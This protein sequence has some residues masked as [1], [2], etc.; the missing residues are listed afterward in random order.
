LFKKHYNST[1]SFFAQA[2]E[3]ACK[4]LGSNAPK[5]DIPAPA[6]TDES[7]TRLGIGE[8]PAPSERVP[9]TRRFSTNDTDFKLPGQSMDRQTLEQTPRHMNNPDAILRIWAYIGRDDPMRGDSRGSTGLAQ[10]VAELL[11]GEMLYVDQAMLDKCFPN[12]REYKEKLRKLIKQKGAPDIVFGTQGYDIRHSSEIRPTMLVS[13]YN[14]DL[15]IGLD[16][17]MNGLVSHDLTPEKLAAAGAEFS[18]RHPEIT[19]DL[20]CIL[21]ADVSAHYVSDTVE[22]L[23]SMCGTLKEPTVY[24]CP[25]RRTYPDEYDSVVKKLKESC[26]T[27]GTEEKIRVITPTISSIRKNYNPYLGL[28]NKA[29]HMVL[30]GYSG[31]MLSEAIYQGRPLYLAKGAETNFDGLARD[32]YLRAINPNNADNEFTRDRLPPISITAAVAEEIA[33]EFDVLSRVRHYS[34]NK[35][36]CG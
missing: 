7:N 22:K 32:G 24:F 17:R 36:A 33:K 13:R 19:G 4:N 15:S 20:V 31:S 1:L 21:M 9:L 29:D 30:L 26:A 2:F 10:Q 14:E 8:A 27:Y 35:L 11:Q 34:V 16:E 3:K 18:S 5:T 12:T 6:A 23:A 28:L 25:S